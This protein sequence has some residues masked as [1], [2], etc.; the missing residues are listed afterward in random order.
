MS[1]EQQKKT[2]R[3]LHLCM[4][5]RCALVG[6]L[7]APVLLGGSR[8]SQPADFPWENFFPRVAE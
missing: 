8:L 1:D 7:K 5:M 4:T 2:F 3:V 6:Q